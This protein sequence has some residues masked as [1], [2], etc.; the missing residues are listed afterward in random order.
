MTEPKPQSP[1]SPMPPSMGRVAFHSVAAGLTPL[2][3]VP[4]LDDYALTQVRENMVRALLKE[5]GLPAPDK[6]VAELAG[7]NDR[8]SIGGHLMGFLKGLVLLPVKKIFRK[9]FFVLWVKDCVDVASV[10]LH[11]G[12][13]LSHAM[14]R[15]DLDAPGLV[16]GAAA[17]KV[18][19]AIVAA[20]K[21]MDARPINQILRRLF[22]SSRLLMAEAARAF[23]NPK[24]TPAPRTPGQEENAEVKS[25]SERL[26]AALWEERGYFTSLEA[27]Y[28]KHLKA[29][30]AASGR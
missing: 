21:E 15:G 12:Y 7:S 27:H 29:G 10:S 16:E 9:V 17:R 23:L 3:P 24:Q 1:A 13:L 30:P 14:D 11:Q 6:A 22:A 19:A 25:L 5:R 8:T 28:D 20:C 4:F 26:L 18:H 2:I